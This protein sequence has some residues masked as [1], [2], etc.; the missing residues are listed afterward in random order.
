LRENQNILFFGIRNIRRKFKIVSHSAR[1]K[2]Q[3]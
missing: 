2:W 1:D 3:H